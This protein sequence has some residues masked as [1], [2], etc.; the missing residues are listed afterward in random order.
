[1]INSWVIGILL[2]PG[3][4][5]NGEV[6]GKMIQRPMLGGNMSVWQCVYSTE[7]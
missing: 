3:A 2:W 4:D 7:L 1:M 5:S 6:I